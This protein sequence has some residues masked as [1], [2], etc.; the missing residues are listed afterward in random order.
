METTTAIAR[1]QG[2][3]VTPIGPHSISIR[4]GNWTLSLLMG[5]FTTYCDFIAIAEPVTESATQLALLRDVPWW[6]GMI[7]ANRVRRKS[8]RLLGAIQAKLGSMGM[9]SSDREWF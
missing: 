4:R 8:V 9:K 1:D 2:F 3:T 6:S 5:V 7:S